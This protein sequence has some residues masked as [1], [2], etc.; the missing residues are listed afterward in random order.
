[1]VEAM[2]LDNK[3]MKLSIIIALKKYICHSQPQHQLLLSPLSYITVKKKKH[4]CIKYISIGCIFLSNFVL[5]LF[6]AIKLVS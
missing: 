6:S 2:Y 1:M 4:C 5:V 3:I